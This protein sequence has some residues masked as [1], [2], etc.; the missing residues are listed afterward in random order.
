MEVRRSRWSSPT[1]RTPRGGIKNQRTTRLGCDSI[2]KVRLFILL[3][4]DYYRRFYEA[5]GSRLQCC[6]G[7]IFRDVRDERGST[8]DNPPHH[9]FRLINWWPISIVIKVSH[10]L[11]SNASFTDKAI[12][13]LLRKTSMNVRYLASFTIYIGS[14]RTTIHLK[15]L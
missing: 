1:S 11:C 12:F 3:Q 6:E 5:G 15:R 7:R 9:G 14:L 10:Y 8:W 4:Q 13:G 2:W